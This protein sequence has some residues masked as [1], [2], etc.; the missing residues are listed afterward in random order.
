MKLALATQ[1]DLSSRLLQLDRSIVD[2]YR[3][4]GFTDHPVLSSIGDMLHAE[5]PPYPA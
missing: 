2:E 3:P 4:L 1:I 5:E